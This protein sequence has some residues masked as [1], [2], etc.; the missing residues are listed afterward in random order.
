MSEGEPASSCGV[1]RFVSMSSLL[2]VLQR[3]ECIEE[4]NLYEVQHFCPLLNLF[5]LVPCFFPNMEPGD[6]D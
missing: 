2:E 6:I 1:G 5:Q 3:Q 4:L